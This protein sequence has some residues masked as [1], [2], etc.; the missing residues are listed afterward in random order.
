MERGNTGGIWSPCSCAFRPFLCC[1]K[2]H[3]EYLSSIPFT[4][5]ACMICQTDLTAIPAKKERSLL[6]MLP[7]FY[8]TLIGSARSGNTSQI[9]ARYW[10][11]SFVKI[12]QPRDIVKFLL[13]RTRGKK[14]LQ[15]NLSNTDTERDRA[16]IRIREVPL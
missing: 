6:Q 16:K 13:K 2:N 5:I 9:A 1:P 3:E 7:G 12:F 4:R 11:S 8:V 14:D 15:S 10:G